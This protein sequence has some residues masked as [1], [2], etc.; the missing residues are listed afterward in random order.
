M[1][2]KRFFHVGGGVTS[3]R[4]FF[5]RTKELAKIK[6][7][8]HQDT[9]IFGERMQGKTSLL[10]AIQRQADNWQYDFHFIHTAGS[11]LRDR[12]WLLWEHRHRRKVA[13]RRTSWRPVILIDEVDR[14]VTRERQAAFKETLTEFRELAND[15]VSFVLAGG[16]RLYRASHHGAF[17]NFGNLVEVMGLEKA[18][19][20]QLAGQLL[21]AGKRFESPEVLERLL[22]VSGRQPYLLCLL[23]TEI[24]AA[25][26]PDD[27]VIRSDDLDEALDS[28]SIIVKFTGWK[29]RLE[30]LVGDPWAIDAIESSLDL[31]VPFRSS[32]LKNRFREAAPS[33]AL[34]DRLFDYLRFSGWLLRAGQHYRYLP[35][36]DREIRRGPHRRRRFKIALSFPGTHRHGARGIEKIA[37]GLAQR[38]GRDRVFYDHFHQAELAVPNA[39]KYL[40]F[41]YHKQSELIVVFLAAPYQQSEWCGVELRVIQD[42]IKKREDSR[43]MIFR[44]DGAPEDIEGFYSSDGYIDVDEHSVPSI[45]ELILERHEL[46]AER[47]R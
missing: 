4:L 32:T 8:L 47:T 9:L 21:K 26:D 1:G 45:I 36:F 23:G 44:L 15:N 16:W 6:P 29:E 20:S 37:R 17:D 31:T 18:A 42:L 28:P 13:E 27:P 7:S 22:D 41:I 38:V 43:I 14:A 10:K 39:K 5:G 35:P 11:D 2:D 19:A 40:E 25:K 12:L 30:G 46:E 33:A 24:L 3:D 34:A